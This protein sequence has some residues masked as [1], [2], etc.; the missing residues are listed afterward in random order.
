M[1]GKFQV[2][3]K[4]DINNGYFTWRPIYIFYLSRSFLLR[5]KNVSDTNCR[6][7]R[8]THFMFRIFFEKRV[9]CEIMWK[10]IVEGAGLRWQYGAGPLHAG[11]LGLQAHTQ[12]MYYF[13]AFPLQQWLHERAAM[14]RYVYIVFH[15]FFSN[16]QRLLRVHHWHVPYLHIVC[17]GSCYKCLHI[18]DI[19]F[20]SATV[21]IGWEMLD[22]YHQ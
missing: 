8:N 20:G 5:M 4:S 10:N 16:W 14:L 11:Y 22:H 18:T 15:T 12:N 19:A 17:F 13:F 2:S 9:V 21:L 1:L 6:K 7:T 3:L